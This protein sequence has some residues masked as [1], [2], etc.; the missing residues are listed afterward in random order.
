MNILFSCIGLRGYIADYFRILLE[1]EDRIIGTSNSAWTTGFKYCDLGVVLP[2]IVS[3]DYLPALITLCR[4]QQVDALLSFFDPDID[5][6]SRHL[7]EFRAEGVIPVLTSP[8]VSNICFDKYRTYL[9]FKEHGLDTPETFLNISQAMNAVD[10]D[11][12]KFPLIV[13]PRYGFASRNI[14]VARNFKEL[15]FFFQ[16]VSD[17]LIQEMLTG[18]QYNFEICNDFQ[19]QVLSVVPWRKVASRA[20]EVNQAETCD[21]PGLFDLGL[22][23]GK[24]LGHLGHVGPLDVDL[25][26]QNDKVFIL[27]MNPRFGGG[28]PMSHLAGADFPRLILEMIRGESPEPEVGQFRPGVIMMKEYNILGGTSQD[29]FGS[30]L[31]MRN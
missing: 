13:K 25:F 11:K 9:F 5:F 24:E 17:M 18:Q 31:N 19:G 10:A 27:E 1:P 26:V 16:Y 28:Y 22:R 30:I 2:D 29:F 7:D 20:G 8:Q 3:P 12:V 6:L 4:E 21:D 15:D 14:F 23:L